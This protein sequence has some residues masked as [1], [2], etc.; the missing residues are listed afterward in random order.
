MALINN[1]PKLEGLSLMG[2]DFFLVDSSWTPILNKDNMDSPT[3]IFFRGIKRGAGKKGTQIGSLKFVLAP[4]PDTWYLVMKP[5]AAEK[6]QLWQA[7]RR[8]Y[9]FS[10][11]SILH[12]WKSTVPDTH[13][14]STP[15]KRQ[16]SSAK[17]GV[18][19]SVGE[20][21]LED[22]LQKLICV[23]PEFQVF[24]DGH[25]LTSQ[26]IHKKGGQN[27][28]FLICLRTSI[29]CIIIGKQERCLPVKEKLTS[30]LE[31]HRG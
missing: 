14:E 13:I 6:Y 31:E 8:G 7:G 15:V 24:D 20:L 17:R 29:L 2:D 21:F 1:H 16:S 28:R 9:T 25:D 5:G 23:Q 11:C 12:E 3:D 4:T 18:S 22:I 10:K 19:R 27:S 26:L 30:H